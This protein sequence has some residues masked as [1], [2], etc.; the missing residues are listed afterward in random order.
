MKGLKG[1]VSVFFFTYLLYYMETNY[2]C[3]STHPYPNK[4]LHLLTGGNWLH[5]HLL[6]MLFFL[7]Q[8]QSVKKIIYKINETF[9][10]FA[11]PSG[12]QCLPCLF[13]LIVTGTFIRSLSKLKWVW[14]TVVK[15]HTWI[16]CKY[17][18]LN[19]A[20]RISVASLFHYSSEISES[21]L[22]KDEKPPE[23]YS[24]HECKKLPVFGFWHSF[25]FQHGF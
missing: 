8:P 22:K 25:I 1:R 16:E 2:T 9:I 3:P 11:S 23:K 18:K 12:K 14:W 20:Q 7:L 6:C 15:Y 10:L 24:I 13:W 5:Q 19:L 4:E 21:W 17:L